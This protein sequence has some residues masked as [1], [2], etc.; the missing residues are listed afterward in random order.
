MESMFSCELFTSVFNLRSH[1]SEQL[2]V[3]NE[4]TYNFWNNISPVKMLLHKNKISNQIRQKSIWMW[5]KYILWAYF[6]QKTAMA[7]TTDVCINSPKT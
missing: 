5:I 2:K 1:N 3:E 6:S 7:S 4:S